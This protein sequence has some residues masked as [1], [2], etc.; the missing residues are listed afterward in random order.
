LIFDVDGNATFKGGKIYIGPGA[1]GDGGQVF[2]MTHSTITGFLGSGDIEAPIAIT[3]ISGSTV[4]TSTNPG[5]IPGDFVSIDGNSNPANNRIWE[6]DTVAPTSYTTTV[7]LATGSGGT[8]TKQAVGAWLRELRVGGSDP[9]TASVVADDLTWTITD[10]PFIFGE[11]TSNTSTHINAS[12]L[13]GVRVIASS[14]KDAVLTGGTLTFRHNGATAGVFIEANSTNGGIFSLRTTGGVPTIDMFG[15][16]GVISAAAVTG[17]VITGTNYTVG[18][19]PGIDLIQ[20]F[21]AS[22]GV[23]SNTINYKDHGGVN[24]SMLVVTAIAPVGGLKIFQKGL[25]TA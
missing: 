25:L 14:G 23:T 6:V 12:P 4:N 20:T 16:S 17:G 3:T 9:A 7:P 8:S 19:T 15:S 24:Q 18:A 5:V 1:T 21:I 13:G 10:I 11:A 2:I 22:V